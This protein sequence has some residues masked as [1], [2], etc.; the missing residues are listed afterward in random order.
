MGSY[1]FSVPV[2][3]LIEDGELLYKINV[4]ITLLQVDL[5]LLLQTFFRVFMARIAKRETA[6]QVGCCPLGLLMVMTEA[7]IPGPVTEKD[8]SAETSVQSISGL[9][10]SWQNPAA[11]LSR[12][13]YSLKCFSAPCTSQIPS[14]LS[15]TADA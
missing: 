2:K 5:K 4:Q 14:S 9:V 3:A 11:F 8:E 13:I 15:I 1:I 10:P 6:V 7:D 12:A